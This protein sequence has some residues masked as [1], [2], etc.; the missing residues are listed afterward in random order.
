MF[1]LVERCCK[2]ESLILWTSK[3][4]NRANLCTNTVSEWRGLMAEGRRSRRA[5]AAGR[6]GKPSGGFVVLVAM[7]DE[8]S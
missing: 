5:G 1:S 6:E 3:Y 7:P 2:S 4:S 8:E